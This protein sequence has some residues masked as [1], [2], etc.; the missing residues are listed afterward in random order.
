MRFLSFIFLFSPGYL[1][2]VLPTVA[3]DT[4]LQD[5]LREV[6]VTA[7][8]REANLFETPSTLEILDANALRLRQARTVPEA[9]VA[10]SGVFNQSTSR[11]GSPFLRGL[12]GNQTLLLVDGIR[13]N[14]ATFRYGPNQYLN[15]LDPFSLSRLE[16]LKGGGSV[17]YGSDRR[18]ETTAASKPTPRAPRAR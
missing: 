11:S 14:N 7:Q 10:T 16:V 17:A 3:G 6:V 13:L 1:L 8:R 15:T 12:T 4:L 2:A 18:I 9:L 5:S